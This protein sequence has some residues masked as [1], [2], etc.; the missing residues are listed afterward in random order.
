MPPGAAQNARSRIFK[1]AR[2][3]DYRASSAGC[4]PGR[5]R[6]DRQNLSEFQPGCLLPPRRSTGAPSTRDL[7]SQP[8][9]RVTGQSSTLYQYWRR[10]PASVTRIDASMGQMKP[11]QH[12]GSAVGR[13]CEP[14]RGRP[15]AHRRF[16][17]R[18]PKRYAPA[19][20][21][22]FDA[23]TLAATG[24]SMWM[25]ISIRRILV[26]VNKSPAWTILR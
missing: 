9:G 8:E 13:V 15:R 25:M 26:P 7:A 2:P 21:I 10:I 11:F 6:T 1:R 14:C 22:A 23:G 24:G 3:Y 17:G 20:A 19:V 5:Q 4:N 18:S 16:A 12:G